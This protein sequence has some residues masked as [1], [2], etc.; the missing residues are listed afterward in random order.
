[1]FL[2]AEFSANLAE[3][4]RII[5]SPKLKTIKWFITTCKYLKSLVYVILA[6]VL[7]IYFHS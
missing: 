2:D 4:R 6:E 7:I 3:L 5:N 1:M